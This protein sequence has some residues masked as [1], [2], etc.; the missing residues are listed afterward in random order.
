MT[1]TKNQDKNQ[2]FEDLG[3]EKVDPS[4]R[5]NEKNYVNFDVYD[6]LE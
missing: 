3:H 6:Y 4:L 2:K 5:L 1:T